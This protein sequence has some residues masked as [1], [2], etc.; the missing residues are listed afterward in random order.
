MGLPIRLSGRLKENARV[1]VDGGWAMAKLLPE[2]TGLPMAVWITENDGYP[3]DVRV[4]VSNLHGGGMIRS[5]L[6]SSRGRGKS[7]L[8]PVGSLGADT[9]ATE[10][11]LPSLAEDTSSKCTSDSNL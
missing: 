10:G 9:S 7:C 8:T 6:P 5:R 1:G 3:H 11:E 2:E 4:K